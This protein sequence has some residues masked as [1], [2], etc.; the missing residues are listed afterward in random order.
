MHIGMNGPEFDRLC[1]PLLLL[2]YLLSSCDRVFGFLAEAR[3]YGLYSP[4]FKPSLRW[5]VGGPWIRLRRNMSA[6]PSSPHGVSYTRKQRLLVTL[7][8]GER[9][10]MSPHNLSSAVLFADA[11]SPAMQTNRNYWRSF[12]KGVAWAKKERPITMSDIGCQGI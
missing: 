4:A 10:T 9:K 11:L 12:S 3:Q 6:A 1:K 2:D 5:T 8:R 7:G